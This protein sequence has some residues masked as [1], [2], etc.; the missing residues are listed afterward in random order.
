MVASVAILALA[1]VI[2]PKPRPVVDASTE[3]VSF[4]QVQP[5]IQERCMSC[6]SKN[7]T[8]LAAAP[9]GVM[10]DDPAVVQGL[11]PNIRLQL[12]THVMPPGNITKMT[13]EERALVIRWVDTGASIE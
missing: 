8:L 12:E 5:I 9:K 6:H 3:G 10:Y 7:P 11:A 4:A 13:E 1:F 2:R